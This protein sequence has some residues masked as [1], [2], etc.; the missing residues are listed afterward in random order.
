MKGRFSMKMMPPN[1]YTYKFEIS[2]DGTNWTLVMD[3][4]DVR[5]K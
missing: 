1:V 3:G 5:S 4:K 2:P